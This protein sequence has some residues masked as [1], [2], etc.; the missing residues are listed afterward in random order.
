MKDRILVAL[1]PEEVPLLRTD[2]EGHF[3]IDIAHS[4]KEALASISDR[5][6][7]IICGVHFDHGAM[8][9]LLKEVKSD[10]EW[11]EIPFFL[12]LR[13][14]TS[15]ADAIIKGIRQA[16]KLLGAEDFIDLG[17][18]RREM[19]DEEVLANLRARVGNALGRE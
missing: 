8:F 14:G 1:R 4:R 7:L 9:D 2:L 13:Q 17:E 6:G 5:T 11:K 15:H 3:N 10:P 18:L 16:A 19:S 12:I